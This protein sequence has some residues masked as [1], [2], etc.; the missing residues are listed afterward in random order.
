[1]DLLI[2]SRNK[3]SEQKNVVHFTNLQESPKVVKILVFTNQILLGSGELLK[4]Y[5]S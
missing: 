1:M 3:Q 5:I 2:S 4:F